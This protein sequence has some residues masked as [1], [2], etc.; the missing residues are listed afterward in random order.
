M[1]TNRNPDNVD[2]SRACWRCQNFG[3]IVAQAHASCKHPRG[4]LQASPARGCVYWA[5]GPGDANPPDWIPDEFRSPSGSWSGAESRRPR[6]HRRGQFGT[7]AAR[8]FPPMRRSGIVSRRG[9]FG[10]RRML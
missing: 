10:A 6:H 9:R 1:A 7:T 3:E 8:A 4:S 5:A 2:V